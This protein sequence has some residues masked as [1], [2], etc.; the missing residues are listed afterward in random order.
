M[1]KIIGV[2]ILGLFVAACSEKNEEYYLS[3]I[4]AAT[5]KL[6]SCEK[7]ME[8]AF[9]SKDKEAFEKVAN[10]PECN[11]AEKAIR[12]NKAIERE[13]EKKRL[14][15]ERQKEFEAEIVA[16]NELVNNMTWSESVN[17]YLK[18]TDCTQG[19]IMTKTPK[20]EAWEAIYR[21]KSDEGETELK[22]LT[23]EELKTKMFDLCKLDQRR[24]SNCSI[25]QTALAEKAVE[26]LVNDDIQTIESKKETY[27]ANDIKNLAVCN[28]SWNNAWKV[29][30]DEW[31]KFYTENDVDFVK[32]Y[33]VCVDQ[34][35]EIKSQNLKWNEKHQL[36]QSVTNTYPCQ[37]AAKAYSTRGM[38]YSPFRVKIA[39]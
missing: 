26:E 11:A 12:K 9:S 7:D 10:N 27:C 34:L 4:N 19:F 13:L 16:I 28:T 36:E 21:A 33:N 15:A 39:E 29:K 35:E 24:G 32:T 30:N 22:L 25:A 23:F 6:A 2:C 3:N 14:E 1:K 18:Q 37:Q 20:C 38:G 5:E 17:E 31:V 8:K